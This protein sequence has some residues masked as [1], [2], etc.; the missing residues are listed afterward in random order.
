VNF[1]PEDLPESPAPTVEPADAAP[2]SADGLLLGNHL[3]DGQPA[4]LVP[5]APVDPA[6]NGWDVLRLIFVTIVA[7]F[8]GV[9]TVLLIARWWFYPHMA[10][11]EIARVPLVVVAGQSVAYLLILAYMYI[12]V[13]RERRRPD[14]LAA[15]HWNWPSNI[16]VYVFVGF[17]LSLALQGLAHLLPMP[18]ELP[19]DSFF[20]TPAEAWALGILSVTLAP[21]VEELFFRGFLYPVLAR[22]LG[23]PVA[24]FLTALGFALLHGAQLGFAWGPVLVIFLVGIVLTMVRGKQNSVA[25]S[26][27]IHMAYNGTITV[28]MFV[29]TDGFRHLEKLNS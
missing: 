1:S 17:A 26:V 16:A 27:L 6:W 19:I 28:A 23:L 25:A 21:L 22:S 10:L 13:T 12:L 11:G 15:I 8:V 24:V 18:K 29:A 7:L 4:E 2:A 20:R 3:P 14:F 5:A 9:F